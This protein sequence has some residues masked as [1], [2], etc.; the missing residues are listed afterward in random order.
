MKSNIKYSLKRIEEK[1]KVSYEIREAEVEIA[2]RDLQKCVNVIENTRYRMKMPQWKKGNYLGAVGEYVEIPV[3]DMLGNPSKDLIFNID[4]TKSLC[5]KNDYWSLHIHLYKF[6]RQNKVH[7]YDYK[8][9]VYHRNYVRKRDAKIG[10]ERL[11]KNPFWYNAVMKENK[12]VVGLV[13][14]VG[15]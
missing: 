9:L 7:S 4:V 14:I 3:V 5:F 8:G 12:D 2:M 13:P 11:M 1:R 6:D 10:L 15:I